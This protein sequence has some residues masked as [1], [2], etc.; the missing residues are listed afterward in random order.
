MAAFR[1]H[2]QA[3]EEAESRGEETGI[4]RYRRQLEA[5]NRDKVIVFCGERFGIFRNYEL[6]LLV[7]V[8]VRERAI[9]GASAEGVLARCRG[10]TP[11]TS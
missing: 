11:N 1:L 3:A 4:D 9:M 2:Q 5:R 7:G 8:E 10:D 6:M